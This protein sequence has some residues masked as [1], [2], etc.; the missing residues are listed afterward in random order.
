[1][2]I[3]KLEESRF[4]DICYKYYENCKENFIK[5]IEKVK[6][7]ILLD[8]GCGDGLFTKQIAKKA[9]AKIIYGIEKDDKLAFKAKEKG[10]KV[11]KIDANKKFPLKSNFFDIVVSNQVLEHLWNIDGFYREV[12]RILKPNGYAL[13]ST[14]NIASLNNLFLLLLSKQPTCFHVSEIQVGN[15]MKG[16]KIDMPHLKAFTIPA[17]V[18]LAHYHGFKVENTYGCGFYLF[19]LAISNLL[20]NIIPQ[21]AIFIGIKIRKK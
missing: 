9:N 8:V 21:Y 18:D 11:L 12:K 7:G 2:K 15:F 10:I 4:Y 14:V 3:R 1:M 17:L 20:S 13:I 19:P 5:R 16:I 6:N